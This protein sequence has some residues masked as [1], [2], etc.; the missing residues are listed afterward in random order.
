MDPAQTQRIHELFRISGGNARKALLS[1]GYAVMALD[2]QMH[3][4]RIAE[5][6]YS[7]VNIHQE[8][9]APLRK[10]YF[11]LSE[12]SMQTT[13]DH[14][15]ALD[16][17]GTRADIDAGRIGVL[18][19]SM[20][21]LEV[22]LLTAVEE[23]IDV[24]VACVVPDYGDEDF[25]ILPKHYARGVGDR[26][27]LMLMGRTDSMCPPERARQLRALMPESTSELVFYQAGH[28]LPAAYV[29]DA[30]AWFENHL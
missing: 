10:R 24:T 18:G 17:L 8:P 6:G 5:N 16:Y 1:S 3:G 2:A 14:R 9:G 4:D 22:F 26:P 23:R 20:G 11:T 25:A 28:Q 30:L 12:I 21:G 29:E 15:R 27:F 13:I 7:P 19:Y